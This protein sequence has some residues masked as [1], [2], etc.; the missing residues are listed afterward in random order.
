[1]RFLQHQ[2]LSFFQVDDII[3]HNVGEMRFLV[4][5]LKGCDVQFN[6][7]F[8]L[9]SRM[10]DIDRMGDPLAELDKV[11]DWKAFRPIL[12]KIRRKERKSNAGRKPYDVVM[13]FKILILQSLYNLADEKMEFYIRDRLS[14]SRFLDIDLGDKVPDANT[15]WDFREALKNH[16]LIDRLF[17]KFDKMLADLGFQA[18]KGQIVDASITEAPRQRNTREENKKI[19]EGEGDELWED[20]PNRRSQKDT[21]ARWTKK[22]DKSYFGYKNHVSV[23]NGHKLIRRYEVTSASVHD[24]QKFFDLLDP[25]NTSSNV[26]ADSA[27]QSEEAIEALKESGYRPHI[28]RKGRRG[29]PLSER[30]QQGNRTRSKTR[31]RIE[32]IFG[33]QSSKA[34]DLIVRTIGLARASVKIGL[35]NLAYNMNRLAYLL[36]PPR[37]AV[38]RG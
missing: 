23:D 24:S 9:Q 6:S 38:G 35:R 32:H 1:M 36:R 13:M 5:A 11:V 31:S 15:I 2:E 20:E 21:D 4:I 7:F 14:F 30:E 34:G 27:Y 33:I 10:E 29:R 12:N 18:T 19:K 37:A 3:F 22:N 17:A 16:D 26:W 28:Q 8:D 25:G